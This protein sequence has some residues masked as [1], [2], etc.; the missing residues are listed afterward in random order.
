MRSI[1]VTAFLALACHLGIG[2]ATV[3][4][5]ERTPPIGSDRERMI[6]RE[7]LV[8]Y[9]SA[10]D[11]DAAVASG[12]ALSARRPRLASVLAR[13]GAVSKNRPFRR[14]RFRNLDRVVR[15][16]L[17]E[18]QRDPSRV[19]RLVAS[20][21]RQPEVE[22]AEPNVVFTA[23]APPNDPFYSSSSS[24]GQTFADLWGLHKIDAETAWSQSQGANV[25]VAVI[26]SGVYFD[27]PDIAN[28][29]W[30]DSGEEGTDGLGQDKRSNGVDDD[31][32]GYVDDWRG[33][34]FIADDNDPGDA[35]G[36]GTHVA[37]TIAAVG[38]NGL[39]IIGVAPAATIM[40]VRVIDAYN[41]GTLDQVANGIIYAADQGARILNLSLGAQ[42][43]AMP[44]TLR[45]AVAYAHDVKGALV[46]AAAGNDTQDVGGETQG[47]FP[48]ALRDVV[49]VSATDSNDQLASFSNFG[50]Q[51]DISAPGGGD[52]DP[53][54]T[55][56]DPHRS[57]LSLLSVPVSSQMTGSGNLIVSS[58]YVRQAGTSMAAPHASGVA[59][60]ALALH[61]TF[62]N[63]QLRQ[64]LRAGSDDIAPAGFDPQTGYG[65][66]NAA[67]ALTHDQPLAVRLFGPTEPVSIAQLSAAVVGTIS[68]TSLN[69]WQL[70]YGVGDSPSSWLSIASGWNAVVDDV[71]AY[72]SLASLDDGAYT[73]RLRAYT[74]TGPVYEDRL[75]VTVDSVSVTSPSAT[76]EQLFGGSNHTVHMLG[77]VEPS[78]FASYTFSVTGA[79]SGPLASPDI[80]LANGGSQSVHLGLLGS[81][82]TTGVQADH[83]SFCVVVT[84]VAGDPIEECVKVLV[85]PDLHDGWPRALVEYYR[86]PAHQPTAYDVN[87]DGRKELLVGYGAQIHLFQDNGLE[88]P[89]WPRSAGGSAMR[90]PV[91]GD[92]TG[93]GIPEVIA[94]NESGGV[95]VWNVDGTPLSGW[96][97]ALF[98]GHAS[99]TIADVNGDGKNEIIAGD[100][101]YGSGN[102]AIVV[103]DEF[104]AAL[105]GWPVT[106]DFG[107]VSS[108]SVGDVDG[109]GAFEIVAASKVTPVRL[110]VL[111]TDGTT[112][113]GWPIM[114]DSNEPTGQWV[115]SLPVL[116]D[117]DGDGA[118]EIVLG[119]KTGRA[120]AFRGDAS[121]LAGWP[122]E[123]SPA[124]LFNSAA[125][126]DIDNDG[127]PEI[128]MG[129]RTNSWFDYL[130]A[131]NADGS[132]L[133]GWPVTPSDFLNYFYFGYG[134]PIIAD[135]DGDGLL[136]IVVSSDGG[137]DLFVL[138]GYRADGSIALGFPKPT[139]GIGADTTTPPAVADLD[140][141]GHYELAWIYNDF[142][143]YY[144]MVW[145]LAGAARQ[146]DPWPMFQ[147][148]AQHTGR[149]SG[150]VDDQAAAFDATL[151]APR[152][153]DVGPSCDS[154]SLLLGRGSLGPEPNQ[155]NTINGSCV[156]SMSGT[157]HIDE[158]NDRI[159]ISTADGLPFASGKNV[160]IDATVWAYSGFSSDHLDLYS[161]ADASSP[162]WTFITTLT[163]T[164]AGAQTL[165]TSYTLPDGALQAVRARFRFG[166]SANPC[167]AESFDDH[168]DLVFAVDLNRSPVAVAG[169]PYSGYRN[170]QVLFDGAASSDPDGD[171][172]TYS[173]TFGDGATATGPTPSHAYAL[174]GTYVATLFV[175]DGK[176]GSAPASANVT[177]TNRAPVAAPG[178]PYQGG[179]DIGVEF[180]GS[181]SSDP[182]GD[183]LSYF[184]NLG[185]GATATGPTP[186]H[187]YAAVGTYVVTLTVSD[188]IV[189]S[190]PASVFASVTPVATIAVYDPIL[191]APSCDSVV[192]ACDSGTLLDGRGPVGPEPHQPNTI[193]NSCADG[194][195]GA[196]H[197]DESLDRIKVSTLDGSQLASGKTVTVEAT[198]W[199]WA[200]DYLDVYY[201]ADA[202]NPQWH[203]VT[204]LPTTS[205]GPQTLTTDYVLPSG[206][207]QAVRL[208][209]RFGAGADPTTM[210]CIE[211]VYTDHDDLVFAVD[212]AESASYYTG[213]ATPWC[214]TPGPAC[215]SCELLV[216]RGSVGPEHHAPNTTS[217]EYSCP[218]G[219]LGEFHM[220][221]SIDRIRVHTDD[222]GDF[223]PDKIVHANITV[224]SSSPDD[225]FD[226]YIASD[227]MPWQWLDTQSTNDVGEGTLSLTYPLPL[228]ER[229][230][231]RAIA[232]SIQGSSDFCSPGD[233]NDHDDLWFVARWTDGDH[234]LLVD[235]EAE[236]GGHGEIWSASIPFNCVSSPGSSQHCEYTQG[237]G[238]TVTLDA[239]AFEGSDFLGWTGACSGTDACEVTLTELRQVGA[240]FSGPQALAVTVSRVQDGVGFV[241]VTPPPIGGGSSECYTGPDDLPVTCS[242][243]YPPDTTV[244]LEP[245]PNPGSKFL[246]WG[247]ACTPGAPCAIVMPGDASPPVEVTAAFLG[248][249]QLTVT[250]SRVQD[251]VGLVSVTPPPIGGGSS[252]CY[253][254]PDDLPV[255]CSFFYPP[256]TTVYLEPY[257]NPGS[258]FLD[259][260]GACT[261]G[262]PCEIVMPGDA[263]PPVEVTAAF[264][265]PQELTITLHRLAEGSGRVELTPPPPLG[266][267]ASSCSTGTSPDPV[268]CA[269]PYAPDTS[270][271]LTAYPEPGSRL[272]GWNGAC[273]GTQTDC[274]VLLDQSK[275]VTATFE[276]VR[277]PRGLRISN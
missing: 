205:S 98:V 157:F 21:R 125:L 102:G 237:A 185:D 180:N 246:D 97:Q 126:G 33:W 139:L 257:P 104:G 48:A 127:L 84:R 71:I 99:L 90:G 277:K 121:T 270:V 252:E 39:G 87:G 43:D 56:Y 251:G 30:T 264:L 77:S 175:H 19:A 83:Y 131:W 63:E 181:A 215:N 267:G 124:V 193:N 5:I 260:G 52:D 183:S 119:T 262:A 163:P 25:M 49:A 238:M 4:A 67:K 103:M 212:S 89:G 254:G 201:A 190:A 65:R 245:Y 116:G 53:G 150:A 115:D 256:D 242:F 105:P 233:Y 206:E 170:Q 137:E 73:L 158:S 266:E 113:P 188:G 176:A 96:P 75:S 92:I 11:A 223:A 64:V 243:F 166:G 273:S 76:E 228:G 66:L 178:G 217:P 47:F 141:D 168:D 138:R 250:V 143:L 79:R 275:D 24:W 130:Y 165:S 85:D 129:G 23:Q 70:D 135:V 148:D 15:Y 2:A 167:G 221:R 162:S 209:F 226:I 17:P 101:G 42:L 263:S 111:R 50:A 51:I 88:L 61:P 239:Y 81:W 68:G 224:W 213:T 28:N 149:L 210:P 123:V 184:W 274:E 229:H 258:K 161:A 128:V 169:G 235:I 208:R 187:K 107:Y 211:D 32:N 265:G 44:L 155:P 219:S 272:Q 259:W 160:R 74:A 58:E 159:R 55:I 6:A 37:G 140:G 216:G 60:L 78:G 202:T 196:Y 261:P 204:T 36:H 222:G 241:S 109:D 269:F 133:S 152:C 197:I 108:I 173:W 57:V 94:S 240:R 207:L 10:D 18:S 227:V 154:G 12:K 192:C 41:H 203:Y 244:Y 100:S 13:H 189:S 230:L 218:D 8:K 276:K 93:D 118:L 200:D 195:G 29:V 117:L 182:D 142:D 268:I 214:A 80:T 54:G 110:T 147:H 153:N 156:D 174:P 198:V 114:L 220:D 225:Q 186:T 234:P 14:A 255:T 191:Q 3:W 120:F 1:N 136:E 177:V 231:I 164:G 46:V 122:V 35:F 145:D 72:W 40:A 199:A 253:T 248:P 144:L 271:Q 26:D 106:T 249:R 7:I 91:A 171:A 27:H 69:D 172:L 16:A 95:Y 179:L 146:S 38:D 62:T 45:D 31:G 22:Y 236:G 232:R 34:D 112:M 9:R 134:Q 20:L 132:Q 82:N 194:T 151:M 247:G 59:A 86:S